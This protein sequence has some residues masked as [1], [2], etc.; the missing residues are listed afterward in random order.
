[1]R[2]WAC[3]V[4]AGTTAALVLAVTVGTTSANRLEFS[5]QPFRA[6]WSSATFTLMEGSGVVR[7]PLTLEGS[8][9]SRVVSKV[10]GSLVGYLT[11]APSQIVCTGGEFH[12]LTETLPWHVRYDSFTGTLPRISTVRLRF[13]GFS[14]W[15]LWFQ[16]RCL[17][18]STAERP[19]YGTRY[20]ESTGPFGEFIPSRFDLEGTLTTPTLECP[21]TIRL[22]GSGSLT[23][24]GTTTAITVA[25]VL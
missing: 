7:C 23:V 13:V 5:N 9:H 4:L 8:L 19:I 16:T 22:E 1:M 12:F 6:S 21:P 14:L 20:S 10:V 17:Y 2:T 25:L 18:R 15:L 24:P 3:G 11:R